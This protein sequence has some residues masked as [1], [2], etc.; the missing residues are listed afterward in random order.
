MELALRQ[1]AHPQEMVKSAQGSQDLRIS[2]VLGWDRSL[3]GARA[4]CNVGV[5]GS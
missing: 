3:N 2:R 1:D 5:Y 4:P